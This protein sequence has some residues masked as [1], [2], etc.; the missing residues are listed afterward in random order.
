M[1]GREQEPSWRRP[2]ISSFSAHGRLPDVKFVGAVLYFF[3]ATPLQ[4]MI[5]R[6]SQEKRGWGETWDKAA[7]KRRKRL[8]EG[9]MR[10]GMQGWDKG[11]AVEGPSTL[12]LCCLCQLLL[13][14]CPTLLTAR[15][16][17]RI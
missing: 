5:H 11:T 13:V 14:N 4:G 2:A 1:E 3:T 12:L 16:A 7:S 9:W 15:D 8:D 6:R 10:D 17:L